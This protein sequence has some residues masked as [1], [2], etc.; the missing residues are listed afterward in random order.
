MSTL[1]SYFVPLSQKRKAEETAEIVEST[2]DPFKHC[3]TN[4][5]DTCGQEDGGSGKDW[6]ECWTLLQKNDFCQR[7]EW[8][9]VNN[10]RLG[11][12]VC[13]DVGGLPV[14]KRMG[15]KISV[16]WANCKISHFGE[17][18]KQQLMSLRK[19]IFEHKESGAHKAAERIKSESKNEKL[20]KVVLNT[21][22]V[23]RTA[24]KV[25][26]KNQAFNNF[27][28]EINLQELNGLDMGYTFH[29]T[30]ACINILNHIADEMRKTLISN[31]VNSKN[32]ISLIIDESTTVNNRITL[33]VSIRVVLP[34]HSAPVSLFL[35]L[36]ELQDTTA[37]GILSSLISHLES[38]GISEDYLKEYLLSVTCDGAAVLF[39]AHGGVKRLI[40]EKF[41]SVVFWRCANH[42][43][44][45]SVSDTV[46][47]VVGVNHFKNFMDKLYVTYHA[48][49]E[50]ARELE[51]CA[52]TLELQLLKIGRILSTRWV[53][54]SFC[55]VFAVWQD[56]EALVY[57]FQEA[58]EDRRRSKTDRCLYE[59]LLRT[60]TS[61][62]FVLDLGLMCDALQ[63]LS[64]LSLDLQERNIDLFTAD[65]KIKN[66]VQ[67][68]EERIENPGPYY[69]IALQS[70]K[71]MK[72]KGSELHKNEKLAPTISSSA[73]YE[74][75]KETVRKCILEGDDADLPE[76][77]KV[78]DSKYWPE[79][80]GKQ[81]TFGETEI[82]KLA[83]KFCLNEKETILGFHEYLEENEVPDK[84]LPLMHAL[85]TIAISSTE[86]ERGLSQMNLTV[87]SS[88]SSLVIRTVSSLMFIRM[89]GPPLTQ[90]N[91]TKYVESWLLQGHHNAVDTKSRKRS[92]EDEGTSEDVSKVWHLL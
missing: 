30:N 67:L 48:S 23:F 11:C 32:K 60:I 68:F 8:L 82:R 42:R 73:F 18:R 54:S 90:F 29:S 40:K 13:R 21:T 27:E 16:E 62:E 77:A 31:I 7:N 47:K 17:S 58:K 10:K 4:T 59:G 72:F 41:P 83:Q 39:G 34:K 79:N 36:I 76:C 6:P 86:C 85:N 57:H 63:V 46:N 9:F 26:K 74:S 12:K 28:D 2:S 37:R 19:K 88:R 24:Y 14:E 53:A 87:T 44:E 33:I 75:L 65:R 22:K 69:N 55:T 66:T 52:A 81:L 89:V 25:A 49:P 80:P 78:L 70:Q 91:P 5:E 38:L 15:M 92:R 84:L 61:C 45:L 1:S 3:K 50:N 71:T 35:D 51:E 56:Y 20:D 43:L 64:E